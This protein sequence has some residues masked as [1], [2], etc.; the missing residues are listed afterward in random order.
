[1]EGLAEAEGVVV[2]GGRAGYIAG[3]DAAAFP[4]CDRPPGAGA[5]TPVLGAFADFLERFPDA[6]AQAHNQVKRCAQCN[7]PCA[8]FGMPA[9]NGC[10][11]SLDAVEVTKANNLF[12]GFI[13]GVATAPFPLKVSIRAET[14]DT[15]V[16]DDPLAITRCHVCAIPTDVYVPDVRVLF[17][18]PAAG[19]ALLKRLDDAAWASFEAGA[20]ADAAW[21]AKALSAAAC[22]MPVGDLRPHVISGFNV[23]PSQYQLHLQ[24]M[25][26]PLLPADRARFQKGIHYTAMRFFPQEYVVEALRAL[27]A[28]AK[29]VPGAGGM[30]AQELTDAVKTAVGVDYVGSHAAAERRYAASNALM[31]NWSAADF[32]YVVS[33]GDVLL[34]DGA[35]APDGAP[36]AKDVDAADKLALQGYGRPYGENGKPGGVYYG[37]AKSPPAPLPTIA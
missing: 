24:Y 12:Y 18:A 20:L 21:K 6:G 7:K 35:A 15:L 37:H 25:L 27:D 14:E 13:F 34:L 3:A 5:T 26:P 31:A 33:D 4:H 16:F 2:V 32:Q 23:P 36:S 9:C 30:N 11:A 1:M 29:A 19:L 28:A 8:I 22:A 17:E 10:G